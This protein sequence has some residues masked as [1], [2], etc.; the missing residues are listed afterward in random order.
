MKTVTSGESKA[1]RTCVLGLV[2]PSASDALLVLFPL[3]Y[4]VGMHA[5]AF[6]RSFV[7]LFVH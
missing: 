1:L 6:A 5:Y 3:F 4:W 2:R 7:K